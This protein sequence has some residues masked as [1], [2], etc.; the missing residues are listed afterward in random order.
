MI[1]V[2]VIGLGSMGEVHLECFRKMDNVHI[3]A[4]VDLDEER[5]VAYGQKYGAK[6]FVTIEEAM[7]EEVD[8]VSVCLPTDQRFEIV[9]QAADKGVDIIC[10]K[11]LA[12]TVA[13]ADKL[14][15]Y[16]EKKSV[17]LFVGHVVRFYPEYNKAKEAVQN[18]AI[19]KLGV[20][21][22]VRNRAFP[23]RETEWYG[24]T[25]RSGGVLLDL[26]VH[27][28]DFLRSC[29]GEVKRVY[30]QATTSGKSEIDYALVTLRFENDIIAHVEG[31]WAHQKDRSAFE[32]AGEKGIIQYDTSQTSPLVVEKENH[33]QVESPF[34]QS[35]FQAQLEHF[36]A[37][38]ENGST[39]LVS[40]GDGYQA[41]AIAEAAAQ[42]VVSRQPVDLQSVMA[43]R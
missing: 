2:M 38:V 36:I 3:K 12:R 18:G 7:E 34:K 10:E 29:F 5:A 37:C 23:H 26:L 4:V 32:F 6:P 41:V 27:D 1:R 16:C 9:K 42:S 15:A 22:T 20:V 25:S 21:R 35:A 8:V 17:R 30:A 24:S 39:P 43:K 13:E 40:A 31:S 33:D 28:F 14:I 19:G 11:P